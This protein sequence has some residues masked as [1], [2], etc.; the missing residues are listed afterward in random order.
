MAVRQLQMLILL[1]VLVQNSACAQEGQGPISKD[2]LEMVDSQI[3]SLDIHGRVV[4]SEGQPLEDVTVLYF[5]REYG[6]VLAQHEIDQKRK[7]V[8]AEFGIKKKDISSVNLTFLKEG[9]YSERWSF[10][11]DENTP[12]TNLGGYER[13]DI[14][15]VMTERPEPAPLR[16]FEGALKTDLDGLVSVVEINR[17]NGRET[18][19]RRN[20][21]QINI[22]WPYLLLDVEVSAGDRFEKTTFLPKGKRT[23]IDAISGGGIRLSQSDFEDGFIVYDPG[24][25][26]VRAELAFRKMIQAPEDGYKLKLEIATAE[27]PRWIYFFC[28]LNGQYGKGM[29]SG[30]PPV[31][32]EDGREVAVARIVVYLNPT[33]SRDVAS[34]HD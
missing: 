5:F 1:F 17:Q 27:S 4:S 16:R 11:F 2:L 10:S 9:Y 32:V 22:K 15:I 7:R 3:G 12:R 33:G 20:G 26:P 8:D 31:V 34:V 13:I 14:E 23:A 30:R 25:I 29:V 28:R 19:L 6:D 21:E 24:D 18:S